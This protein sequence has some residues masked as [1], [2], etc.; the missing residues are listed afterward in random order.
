MRYNI[1]MKSVKYIK[2]IVDTYPSLLHDEMC[3]MLVV[4]KGLKQGELGV[5]SH[6]LI[7]Q[8]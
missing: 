5:P 1:I 6:H 3:L 8:Q 2:A 4:P 7:V